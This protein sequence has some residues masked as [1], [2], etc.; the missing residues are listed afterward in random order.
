GGNAPVLGRPAWIDPG[1]D[2][3]TIDGSDAQSLAS[4]PGARVPRVGTDRVLSVE[5]RVRLQRPAAGRARARLHQTGDA[6]RAAA[7]SRFASVRRRRRPA[8]VARARG[9]GCANEIL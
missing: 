8:L 5:R 3:G 1:A 2:T 7:A 6:P 9:T 4:L